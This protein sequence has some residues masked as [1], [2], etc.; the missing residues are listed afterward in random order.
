MLET[1]HLLFKR[2]R[3]RDAW[4]TLSE[5]II[6]IESIRANGT[7][8]LGQYR[9]ALWYSLKEIHYS[10]GTVFDYANSDM[11]DRIMT[12][13]GCVVI[14]TSGLSPEMASLLASLFI[15]YAYEQR[16]VTEDVQHKLLLFILDDA[17]PLVQETHST[18]ERINPLA[19]WAFLG[20]SR[21]IGFV[22]SA[23]NWSLINSA[24]KNNAENVVCCASYGRDADELARFMQLTPDQAS[25]LP[26]LR[27][28]EV[29]AITRGEHPLA[30]RGRFPEVQ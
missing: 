1:L 10:L 28:G 26:M 18:Y 12:H 17:L 11:I 13:R 14:Q 6:L 3:P 30:V 25:V 23:Q 7:S 22:L 21:G 19:R 4:P 24:L 16:G 20:R 9:E 27:P 15:N 5:W 29:I 8:R 2:S